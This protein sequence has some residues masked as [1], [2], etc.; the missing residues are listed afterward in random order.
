MRWPSGTAMPEIWVELKRALPKFDAD[1][2]G[3]Y[4]QAEVK[5]AIDSLK[6]LDDMERAALW[7]MTTMGKNN[8]YNREVG[9]EM[10][11]S[12][13]RWSGERKAAEQARRKQEMEG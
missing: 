13:N 9:T 11:V 2:S 4:K 6:G 5:S 12:Y 7:Q 10:Y 3:T 8:P 1:Y